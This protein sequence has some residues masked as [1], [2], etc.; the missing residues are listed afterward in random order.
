[1]LSE[2]AWSLERMCAQYTLETLKITDN[3]LAYND[4]NGPENKH[5]FHMKSFSF[6]LYYYCQS[7]NDD[8]IPSTIEML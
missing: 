6:G 5:T 2:R 8:S 1:M 7:V 3:P 4:I